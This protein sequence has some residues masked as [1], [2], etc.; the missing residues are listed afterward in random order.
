[1]RIGFTTLFSYRPHVEHMYYL[2]QQLEKAGHEVF[3]LNCRGELPSCYTN[4]LRPGNKIKECLKCRVGSLYSY[5]SENNTFIKKDIKETF[6][7]EEASQLTASSSFTL[8]RIEDPCDVQTESVQAI[9]KRLKPAVEIVYANAKKWIKEQRLDFVF[10]FNGRMDITRAVMHACRDLNI[11]FCAIE[12]TLFA[13]GLQLNFNDNALSLNAIHKLHEQFKDKPLNMEQALSAAGLLTTRFRKKEGLEWRTYNIDRTEVAWPTN[14]SGKKILIMPSSKNE[15]WAESDWRNEWDEYPRIFE[16]V[17][18]KLGG[19]YSNVVLRSHPNWGQNIGHASGEKIY[20]YYKNWCL[21]R[22]IE[23]IE[24]NSSISSSHLMTQADIVLLNGSSAVYE[25]S[26]LAVP[27]ICVSRCRY[28]FANLAKIILSDKDLEDFEP[29]DLLNQSKPELIRRLLR[30]FYTYSTRYAIFRSDI[31]AQDIHH[32]RYSQT[33][34]VLRLEKMMQTGE[35]IP[36]D[37][38]FATNQEAE[39]EIIK[40]I[41][42]KQW[43]NLDPYQSASNKNLKKLSR[44]SAYKVVDIIRDQFER[45][46]I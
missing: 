42:N 35:L 45:G 36:D 32:F 1:M 4:E 28:Q 31:V 19:D 5:T 25:S 41:L 26:V 43:N 13:S 15:I 38:T 8:T 16:K 30:F 2:M 46:D 7:T 33:L 37:T 20:N 24:P 34:D 22:G 18:E 3:Q 10:F 6:S 17:I 14:G 9:Q 11:K 12:R 39:D 40:L 27:T 29:Q 23:F 44:R 21:T